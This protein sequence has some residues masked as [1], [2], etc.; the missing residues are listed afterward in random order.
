MA[1]FGRDDQTAI[2]QFFFNDLIADELSAFKVTR[3]LRAGLE[4]DLSLGR[5][6]P[7]AIISRNLTI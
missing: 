1:D 2:R 5:G 7:N 3:Y 4:N 6:V